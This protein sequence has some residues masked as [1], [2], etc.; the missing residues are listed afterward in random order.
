MENRIK[1][2]GK[3]ENLSQRVIL[4]NRILKAQERVLKEAIHWQEIRMKL[5]TKIPV[6]DLEI[7]EKTAHALAEFKKNCELKVDL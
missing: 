2:L 5:Q 6:V 1:E 3:D 4:E 7:V